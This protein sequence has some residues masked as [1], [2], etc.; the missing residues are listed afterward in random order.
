MRRWREKLETSEGRRC[1]A[2][3]SVVSGLQLFAVLVA[4]RLRLTRA[5]F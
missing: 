1:P 3:P 2:I 5:H 4:A